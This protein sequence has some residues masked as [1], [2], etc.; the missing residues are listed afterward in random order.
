M[1]DATREVF[2]RTQPIIDVQ[3]VTCTGGLRSVLSFGTSV[4]C[5]PRR[6]QEN[7]T[8][9]TPGFSE[10]EATWATPRVVRRQ[11]SEGGS[12]GP[13]LYWGLCPKGRARGT[14]EDCQMWLISVASKL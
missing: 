3:H 8:F 5:S 11:K 9:Y 14:A 6:A 10:W 4:R 1:L 2:P 7:Q 12:R 13:S